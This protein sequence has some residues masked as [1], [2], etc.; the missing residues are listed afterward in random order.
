MSEQITEAFINQYSSGIEMLAQQMTSRLRQAVVVRPMKG[1]KMDQDQVGVVRL[2]QRQGRHQDIPV[3]ETPHKRRWVTAKNFWARDF[4]DE[5]DKLELLN[6]PTNSY[7]QAFA[8]AAAREFDFS[9]VDGLLGTN[10]TGE[11]G[12]TP[13]VLPAAQKIADGGTGFTLDK[14]QEGVQRLKTAHAIMPGDTIHCAWT[15]KQEQEFV[16]TTEVKSSDFTMLRVLDAGGVESFYK[17]NFHFLEDVEAAGDMLPKTG[18]VRTCPLW[19]RSGCL[20]GER[21]KAGGRIAWLD[22]KES[23]QVSG[24]WSGGSTRLQEVKVVQIDVQEA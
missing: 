21:R 6:D 13:I 18:T 11:E 15:A 5:F 3:I 14:L 24:S 17:V 2:Q 10:F 23:W 9:V 12:T 19:V 20:V 16:N 22:E 8:A 4:I 7:S 1:K